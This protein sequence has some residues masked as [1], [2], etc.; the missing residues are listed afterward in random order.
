MPT[1]I[2]PKLVEVA[3]DHVEGAPFERFGHAFYPSIYGSEFVPLGGTKDGG[4][5]GFVGMS[6]FDGRS[7]GLFMQTSVTADHRAKIRAT[8]ER[9]R[10]FGR[11]PK[12]LIYLSSQAI[13]HIDR[14]EEALST[15]LN[16]T[17][18]IR[19]RRYIAYH[20]NDAPQTI[21]AFETFLRPA[22]AFLGQPGSVPVFRATD[23]TLLPSVYVFLRQEAERR[24]GNSS[25]L[26][27]VADAL[28]LWALE[29]TD[30]DKKIFMTR[31][32]ILEKIETTVPP[33][34]RFIRGLLDHRLEILSSKGNVSGREIRW[35]RKHNHFCLPYETR[36]VVE[37]ENLEDE[38]LRIAVRD[39]FSARAAQLL[40]DGNATS[41]AALA[42]EIAIEAIHL[43]FEKE[44][45]EFASFLTERDEATSFDT[46][47]DN[48]DA[49]LVGR[50]VAARDA[51]ILKQAIIDVLRGAFYSSSEPERVY[52]S[53]LAR[54]FSLFF[55]LNADP[56]IVE[57]FQ[58]MSAQF[59][60]YVGADILVKALSERYLAE[61]DQTS[62]NLLKM[63]SAAGSTL[64][65]AEPVLMEVFTHI[66]ATNYEFLNYFME[67]EPYIPL[68]VAAQSSK[69]LIRAYFYARKKPAAGVTPP[70]GW[71][72]YINQFCSYD[73]LGRR[74]GFE[75]LK[76]Y[77][78]TK[79]GMTYEADTDLTRICDRD[80]VDE[81][82]RRL[83]AIKS[84]A[85]LAR[86]DAIMVAAVYGRRA[87]LREEH[88]PSRYGYRTWW[89]THETR[90]RRFT[91]DLYRKHGA[92]YIMR[93]EFIL[94]F[95]ALSPSAAEVVRAYRNV[96]P[97]VLGIS[98]AAR[99]KEE[100]FHDAMAK[101]KEAKQYEEA[102]M[103]ALIS[104]LSDRVKA[105]F[106]KRYSAN[107]E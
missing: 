69:I 14:E 29:G 52:F 88:R 94:N 51:I 7:N 80:V 27:A 4:A 41:L 103:L 47:S 82:A 98:L 62:S 23:R 73:Q 56:Q 71:R 24:L 60:L 107:L 106:L 67:I 50:G 8:V 37:V 6:L 70:A 93:P 76:T 21:A 104:N 58:S 97:S 96:F 40:G 44:G 20:I 17:V 48:V 49:I 79:F 102:R 22:T 65:L 3:L 35:H 45:L 26:E 46:V 85:A 11:D 28:I 81:L 42:A 25:L 91:D 87:E 18:R 54:T 9:L 36:Q 34:K 32:Q 53:K 74:A 68:E 57:Y 105:D 92:H 1:T 30:P 39:S 31:Q 95:I 19:D 38:T 55:S 63:L 72:A 5:D 61:A 10:E 16:V 99:M 59:Y 15:E 100:V 66:A 12:S 89:L 90:I 64:V 33:A 84:D 101:A 77:L 43:T 83:V 75:E 86:N 2:D 13:Q 78:V